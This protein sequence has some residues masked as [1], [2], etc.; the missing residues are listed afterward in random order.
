ML[1]QI[2]KRTG[3]QYFRATDNQTLESFYEQIN[4][5]EKSKIDQ[6]QYYHYT[7][8]YSKFLIWGLLLLLFELTL[9]KTIYKE[10]N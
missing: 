4:K 1:K 3:G 5:L 8:L 7:E 2:A 6:I 9:R 10:I